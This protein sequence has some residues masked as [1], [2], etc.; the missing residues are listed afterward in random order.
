MGN[1]VDDDGDGV[2]GDDNDNGD[3]DGNDG[4]DGVM[5]SGGATYPVRFR[6]ATT[7]TTSMATGQ[8]ATKSTM[9][10]TA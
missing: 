6:R 8:R 4:G 7:T 5:G 2:T 10:A 3:H 9:M 1:E